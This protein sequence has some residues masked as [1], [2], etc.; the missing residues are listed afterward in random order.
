MHDFTR[1]APVLVPGVSHQP[2]LD[3]SLDAPSKDL[4]RMSSELWP[5]S[6]L[7]DSRLV[8]L[9]RRGI[10]EGQREPGDCIKIF[11]QDGQWYQEVLV[12]GEGGLDRAVRHDFLFNRLRH[13]AVNRLAVIFLALDQSLLA[14]RGGLRW[15]AWLVV[16]SID[17][18]LARWKRW[19]R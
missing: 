8:C 19:P 6:V 4:D 16:G 3:A 7:V 11:K 1:V 17:V 18:V 13:H 9:R 15:A 12:D 2:V 14:F 5:F 10:R